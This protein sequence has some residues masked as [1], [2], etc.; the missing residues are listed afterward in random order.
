MCCAGA[1]THA[2]PTEDA[3]NDV[4]AC[5][6]MAL[7]RPRLQKAADKRVVRQVCSAGQVCNVLQPSIAPN[8][9]PAA[10]TKASA[11]QRNGQAP[12]IQDPEQTNV[13]A[14]GN[15]AGAVA[16][17]HDVAATVI[18]Q[19]AQHTTLQTRTASETAFA[20]C[21]ATA[22]ANIAAA[23]NSQSKMP[24]E[25]GSTALHGPHEDSALTA[26]SLKAQLDV[27]DTSA[28]DSGQVQHLLSALGFKGLSLQL[29]RR[30]GENAG[31]P[32]A[33]LEATSEASHSHFL[34][35]D[36]RMPG[37]RP[38]CV[39]MRECPS[40]AAAICALARSLAQSHD[41]VLVQQAV[42]SNMDKATAKPM[43]H[44][45]KCLLA[46]MSLNSLVAQVLSVR[47]CVACPTLQHLHTT[48]KH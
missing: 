2:D 4:T 43:L 27:A 20:C 37:R 36:V 48:P 17:H 10:A 33:V 42:F 16:P 12:G 38:I 45:R 21:M 22:E 32:P 28:F 19:D 34:R 26:Y 31:N 25:A 11:T 15:T 24:P 41:Q 23:H 35:S 29:V 13:S 9:G 1:T 47:L 40:G 8:N 3:E 6:F 7:S 39:G 14:N 30:R 46:W 44:V 18:G 5:I